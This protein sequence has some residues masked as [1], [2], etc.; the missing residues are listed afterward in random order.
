MADSR[1]RDR[2]KPLQQLYKSEPGRAMVTDRA[3]T[4]GHDPSDPFRGRVLADKA[5]EPWLFGIHEKVGGFSD[6]PT[7]GDIL[8]AALA[9]CLESTIRMIAG[10]LRITLEALSVE[11]TAEVDVRGTLLV[12]PDVPVGFLR[13]HCA[14]DLRV[15]EDS[16]PQIVDILYR[17]A[18]HSCIVLSTLRSGI[19]V[20]TS[21]VTGRPARPHGPHAPGP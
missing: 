21:L 4:T 8:C 11:V 1:V 7:S 9:T 2:Q 14:T 17:A 5:D 12:D 16:D 3:R 6:A 13:V 15:P 19:P 10:R 18:E 20:T